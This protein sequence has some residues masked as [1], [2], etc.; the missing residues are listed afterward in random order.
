MSPKPASLLLDANAVLTAFSRGVWDALMR[1]YRVVLPSIVVRAEAQFYV[2]ADGDKKIYLDLEALVTAK[3]IAEWGATAIQLAA[4]KARFKTSFSQGLDDGETEAIACLL[5]GAEPEAV[6]ITGDRI[7]I[8]AVTM[9]D[10]GDR[11]SCLEEVL[12]LCGHRT[13]M[14]YEHSRA[15]YKRCRVEGGKRLVMRDGLA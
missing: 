8:H 2:T 11:A 7:A 15:Y 13:A 1:N 4:V 9:L 5:S 3:A 12:E 10:M 14:P 6:F